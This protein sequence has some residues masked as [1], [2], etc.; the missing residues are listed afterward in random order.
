MIKILTDI[1]KLVLSL[2]NA[3]SGNNDD[4]LKWM[5]DFSQTLTVQAFGKNIPY[6]RTAYNTENL[7]DMGQSLS[8]LNIPK[9]FDFKPFMQAFEN[10]GFRPFPV[11]TEYNLSDRG[12]LGEFIIRNVL[13]LYDDAAMHPNL[14]RTENGFIS[15][16]FQAYEH[17][18]TS[19]IKAGQ[20]TTPA[21]RLAKTM[22][23]P[24]KY[25]S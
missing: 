19:V 11:R 1:E 12:D 5:A 13:T 20:N 24:N 3:L 25:H 21:M 22:A 10:A 2:D 16:Y 8:V 7:A 18:P 23:R 15:Q 9:G 17:L 4:I 6:N 14:S